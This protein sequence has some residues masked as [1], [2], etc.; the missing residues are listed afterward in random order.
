MPLRPLLPVCPA[1]IGRVACYTCRNGVDTP[2]LAWR[3]CCWCRLGNNFAPH[4]MF[5][6]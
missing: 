4:N 3:V 6:R 1:L 2:R 5:E